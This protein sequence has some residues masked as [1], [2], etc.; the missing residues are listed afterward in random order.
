[1]IPDNLD[2]SD[3]AGIT[4][5]ALEQA[6]AAPYASM[7]LADAGAR[8]IKI[9]RPEGDFARGYDRHV[10]GQSAYFVWLSRGKQ[11]V[12][13]DLRESHDRQLLDRMI[14]T[15]DVFLHNL[16]PGST[17]K[18]GLSSKRLRA[19][20]PRL[21]IC[22]ISGFGATGPLAGRKAYDLIV[23]AEAGLCAI[24]GTPDGP[25]R[26]GVSLCDIAAGVTAH[27]AILQALFAR[28]RTGRGRSIEVALFDSLAE[29][30]TVPLLQFIYG[31]VAAARSGV[32]HPTIAP[33]GAFS[34]STGET[35]ILAI[36]NERE[37]TLFCRDV[38][39]DGALATHPAY[40]DNSA[41]A[42]NRSALDAI[43]SRVLSDTTFS[44]LTDRLDRAGVAYGRLN[45]LSEAA[46][47]P[48]LRFVRIDTPQG[49]IRVVA[50]AAIVEG[51]RPQIL[52]RIPA[53]GEHSDTVR[54]EVDAAS[55]DGAHHGA[56]DII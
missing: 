12:C 28:E 31:G 43:V 42:Q 52:G 4:V 49:E 44:D 8:V 40:H 55:T 47:H 13:L 17:D 3:L 35:V 29:W 37:W 19:R 53:L 11:S 21:I 20:D 15:A 51:T 22:E 9:E 33:Y 36:Q 32:S 14:A 50:P 27:A 16:K 24:T 46:E 18:L 2:R 10:V 45:Q 26:T 5:V 23:Q 38:L 7:R 39:L 30:M 25:A 6:V 41:R 34:C 1:M 48:H 56:A 54:R